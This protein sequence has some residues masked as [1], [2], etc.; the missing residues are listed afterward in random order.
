M[1]IVLHFCHL[2]V[3]VNGKKKPP[4]KPT[5]LFISIHF[6][7][8]WKRV[9]GLCYGQSFSLTVCR[10]FVQHT[11][12]RRA[13]HLIRFLCKHLQEHAGRYD[14][15][16]LSY[17]DGLW[18]CARIFPYTGCYCRKTILCAS[19]SSQYMDVYTHLNNCSSGTAVATTITTN[20]RQP[21]NCLAFLFQFLVDFQLRFISFGIVCM[22]NW[23][24]RLFYFF[25]YL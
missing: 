10:L 17:T 21:T 9:N 15:C 25:F 23:W 7:H 12:N 16:K 18:K 20:K 11:K 5:S 14:I 4:K 24:N 1:K 8:L 19:P 22:P 3:I 2:V 13:E 6:V